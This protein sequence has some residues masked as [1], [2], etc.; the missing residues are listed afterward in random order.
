MQFLCE[1]KLHG[2]KLHGIS[3]NL[4]LVKIQDI[5]ITKSFYFQ[6]Y[7]LCKIFSK[8][9]SAPKFFTFWILL[10]MKSKLTLGWNKDHLL[11]ESGEIIIVVI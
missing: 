4:F 11:S 10:V 6:N 1:T 7:F 9:F 3:Y 8:K 5:F 2:I